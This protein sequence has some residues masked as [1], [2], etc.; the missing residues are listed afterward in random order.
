[1]VQFTAEIDNLEAA[2][3]PDAAAVAADIRVGNLNIFVAT[4]EW[5]GSQWRAD[6]AFR[7]QVTPGF[8]AC[9]DQLAHWEVFGPEGEP[10][11]TMVQGQ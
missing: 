1:V 9:R 7:P 4:E 11:R 3:A 6:R 10:V 8:R 2:E 5:F